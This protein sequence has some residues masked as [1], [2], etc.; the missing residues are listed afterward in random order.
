MEVRR[1]VR[2]KLDVPDDRRAD[3][4]ASIRQFNDAANYGRPRVG[5]GYSRFVRTR[6][7]VFLSGGS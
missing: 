6:F 5:V 7:W 1:T 2:V 4:P 3:L